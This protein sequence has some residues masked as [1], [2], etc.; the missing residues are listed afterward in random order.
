MLR[1]QILKSA[2][3]PDHATL[4]EGSPSDLRMVDCPFKEGLL[5]Q[6]DLCH[7]WNDCAW[8]RLIISSGRCRRDTEGGAEYG[9]L[10]TVV[11]ATTSTTITT[12]TTRDRE[13]L[14]E[15]FRD[16]KVIRSTVFRRYPRDGT[17]RGIPYLAML[18]YSI[19]LALGSSSRPG[20]PAPPKAFFV[21]N[22]IYSVSMDKLMVDRRDAQCA[23]HA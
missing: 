3:D 8:S 18:A 19:H 16:A 1:F 15:M 23:S 9:R 7:S 5:L 10:A 6:L 4:L 13:L 20:E 21:A 14:R 2:L 11:L 12:T 17:V 22:T